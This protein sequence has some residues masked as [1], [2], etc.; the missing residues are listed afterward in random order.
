MTV[1]KYLLKGSA[2]AIVG[3]VITSISNMFIVAMLARIISKEEMGVFFLGQSIASF[4][5]ISGRFGIEN[6][7]LRKVSEYLSLNKYSETI[8]TI[9]KSLLIVIISSSAVAISY[10]SIGPWVAEKLFHSTVLGNLNTFISYWIIILSF[11]FVYAE[12]FRSFQNIK[13]SVLFGGGFFSVAT[14]CL[15]S[16]LVLFKIK[17]DIYAA[18]TIIILGRY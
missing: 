9:Y 4:L 6:T 3:K 12:I 10:Y 18:L 17:I 5:A 13:L 16:G 1:T 15:L 8:S 2:Y 14:V 7:I 11:Q